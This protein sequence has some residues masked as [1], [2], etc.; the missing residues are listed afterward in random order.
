MPDTSQSK[1]HYLHEQDE[2]NESYC[3]FTLQA[4]THEPIVYINGVSIKMEC[5]TSAS[6]SDPF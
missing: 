3:M 6:R 4:D 2:Q 5:D 1:N